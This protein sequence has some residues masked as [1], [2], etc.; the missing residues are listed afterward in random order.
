MLNPSKDPELIIL[1]EV[2]T[3]Q[4]EKIVFKTDI[5]R[6]VYEVT[7]LYWQLTLEQSA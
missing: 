5:V 7:I 6:Y 1:T 2:N 3:R 4:A